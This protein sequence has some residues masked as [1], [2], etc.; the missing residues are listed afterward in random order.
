MTR[1]TR[2]GMG[3]APPPS[4]IASPVAVPEAQVFGVK[5]APML[6][7]RLLD[8]LDW[9]QQSVARRQVPRPSAGTS[10]RLRQSI[11][12]GARRRGPLALPEGP[13]TRS[14]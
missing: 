13:L 12:T 14:L 4:P 8:A 11:L 9:P 1:V 5:P 2:V 7:L 6:A 10:T 3:N